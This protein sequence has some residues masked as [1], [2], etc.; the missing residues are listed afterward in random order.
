M[1][2]L[3][4]FI[5]NLLTDGGEIVSLLRWQKCFPPGR[6]LIHISVGSSVEPKAIVLLEELGKL[7]QIINLIGNRTCDLPACKVVAEPT[8]DALIC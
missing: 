8:T 4:H 1:S 5:E 2:R 3:P 6:L 7:K